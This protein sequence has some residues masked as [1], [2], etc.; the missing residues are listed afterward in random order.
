[1]ALQI[2]SKSYDGTYIGAAQE[3][4]MLS[5]YHNIVTYKTRENTG[6]IQ[7]DDTNIYSNLSLSLGGNTYYLQYAVQPDAS[8]IDLMSIDGVASGTILKVEDEL[9]LVNSVNTATR[10]LTVTRGYNNTTPVYHNS[11]TPAIPITNYT[12]FIARDARGQTILQTAQQINLFMDPIEIDQDIDESQIEFNIYD[13][14]GCNVGDVFRNEDGE[15]LTI[16][17][18]EQIANNYYTIQVE[19]ENAQP[20]LRGDTFYLA[21]IHDQR[22]H[23]FHY[24]TSP[25]RGSQ[26]G[27]RQ[28]IF[29]TLTY[30]QQN[31]EDPIV[32]N[33]QLKTYM[34]LVVI[35]TI[36]DSITAGHA[37]FRAEDHKG[38]YCRNGVSYDNDNTNEDVTSQY[39]YWLSYRLGRNYNIYNY[40]TGEEVGY[41]VGNRFV[42]EILA[43][44]PDYV[45]IQC[46]TNDLSLF[47]GASV[48]S[49]ID[50]SS[51]MDEW[52]F[53]ETPIVLNKNNSNITYY[54]LVP[55]VKQMVEL[56]IEND[57]QPIIGNLLPRNGLT[58]D[59]RLA[60]DAYNKWLEEY[61]QSFDNVYMIDFFNG[62]QDGEFLR[63]EPE[64][65]TNYNMNDRYSSGAVVD[66]NGNVTVS[67][68]GIHL[69]SAGYRIM[70][71]CMN[72]D[73]LFDA[74]VEGFE[75]YHVPD[76]STTPVESRLDPTNNIYVYS[77]KYM[78]MQIGRA[79]TQTTYLYN[80]G[81]NSE[82]YYIY[83]Y[84][85]ENSETKIIQD[86][87]E[88]ESLSGILLPGD[89]LPIHLKVTPQAGSVQ[90]QV[91]VV[92]RPFNTV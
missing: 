74:S 24:Q 49:G 42:R 19:R 68:D 11:S 13:A 76:A 36:G 91:R 72:I 39:Q 29:L 56:A 67:G 63:Q 90:I 44:H 41:Q 70:G 71:Y 4:G 43:L 33:Y 79:K 18:K 25:I 28:D 83:L 7:A 78:L 54:G 60:F 47:N 15:K 35:G 88:V 21:E 51:T 80:K 46:G 64:S 52:I 5:T 86:N 3:D 92:G 6:Y 48:V 32:Q 85:N 16:T 26:E 57:V 10:R 37:A 81:A 22:Y 62:S 45:I 9:I 8:Y 20:H 82:L 89:F 12:N 53:T 1:M 58:A 75:L 65:A 34:R 31:E 30:N 87:E 77:L 55:A 84:T 59:M 69:N 61:V 14:F 73:I 38:T 27:T 23:E 66:E 40:G 2:F 17:S 50:P